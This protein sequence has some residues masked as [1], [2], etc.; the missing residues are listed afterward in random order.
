MEDVI[1]AVLMD[2]QLIP[3]KL[4]GPV[5]LIVP[6]MYAYKSVKWL[7]AIELI[8]EEHVGYWEARGYDTDAWVGKSN[9]PLVIGALSLMVAFYIDR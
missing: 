5:R 7:K 3:Q 2:G 8:E 4:G 6:Q 1:V 9:I